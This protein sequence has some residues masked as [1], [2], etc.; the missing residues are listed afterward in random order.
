MLVEL[1]KKH[2]KSSAQIALRFLL[3]SD[4]VVIPKSIRKE[5]MEENIN[6]FDFELSEDDMKE[7]RGLDER[8]SLFFS[9]YDVEQVERLTDW[10]IYR[11]FNMS[12]WSE[13]LKENTL[14]CV[15]PGAMMKNEEH[16]FGVFAFSKQ[17]GVLIK[18]IK[19]GSSFPFVPS[20]EVIASFA[21][22]EEMVEAGWVFD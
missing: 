13:E 10:K 17:G 6:V 8:L 11:R 4:V 7:I 22:I 20:D 1:A 9:H 16:D 2:K 15:F 3:Q 12:G 18:G 21:S 5:R 19:D 14:N